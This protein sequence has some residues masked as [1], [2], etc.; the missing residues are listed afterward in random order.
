MARKRI[1]GANFQQLWNHFL[2][3]RPDKP[4]KNVVPS[5]FT[6][7]TQEEFFRYQCWFAERGGKNRDELSAQFRASGKLPSGE[8]ETSFL[9]IAQNN[10]ANRALCNWWRLQPT[11]PM[12]LEQ[13]MESLC[14]IHEGMTPDL[15]VNAYWCITHDFK[16]KATD[17]INGTPREAFARVVAERKPRLRLVF[18]KSTPLMADFYLHE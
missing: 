15:L 1:V 8:E 9:N 2:S 14:I 11:A 12:P 7:S 16:P 3:A 6:Q 10:E 5:E 18:Q 17:F 13:V 4:Q